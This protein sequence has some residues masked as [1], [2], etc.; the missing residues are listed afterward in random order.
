MKI[1]DSFKCDKKL[2]NKTQFVNVYSVNCDEKEYTI[3]MPRKTANKRTVI[4]FI[5]DTIYW[6][7]LPF[8]WR[9]AGSRNGDKTPI[10]KFDGGKIFN[11]LFVVKG[12]P[13]ADEGLDNG[14]FR[15]AKRYDENFVNCIS[16]KKFKNM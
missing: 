16:Y 14:I 2:L 13:F 9:L 5:D 12:N 6:E 8:N 1:F 7:Q 15:S 11:T 10:Y 3:I 4:Y